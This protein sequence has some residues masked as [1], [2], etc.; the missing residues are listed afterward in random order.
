M[1]ERRPADDGDGGGGLPLS[2]RDLVKLAGASTLAPLAG[3]ASV[4]GGDVS[5]GDAGGVAYGYGGA[6]VELAH[7]TGDVS[8]AVSLP[9]PVARWT[10]DEEGGR[11]V[12]DVAGGHHGTTEGRPRLGRPGVR[13]AGSMDCRRRDGNY[14]R[15]PSDPELVPTA[16]L[17]FGGWFRTRSSAVEQTVVQK[18]TDHMWGSGYVLDVQTARS[19]RARVGV[20]SGRA[21]VNPWADFDPHDGEWH[22]LFAT[23]DGDAL[24][25]YYDGAEVGRDESQ[26]GAVRPDDSP[27]YLGRGHNE[28]NDVYDMGGAIDDV[29]VYDVALPAASVKALYDGTSTTSP[30]T[31]TTTTTSDP[32]TTTTSVPTTTTT[33]T[34]RAP[35]T[36]STTT[37]TT[38]TTTTSGSG[39]GGSGG[40]TTTTSE[41]TT[42]TTTPEPTTT[43]TSSPEDDYGEQ[44][45]GAYG[46]GG[47]IQ[48]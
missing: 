40:S 3:C 45:Y 25:C 15:V 36:T 33:A 21:F 13:G 26:S 1:D 14:V 7:V 48:S 22:H 39:G 19:F 10:L 27:L 24:V 4:L 29:R 5:G 31:P 42:T 43:T 12:R 16:E 6:R 28:W 41:P 9:E 32:T 20:D 23:W 47:T 18:A 37:T 35:T 2:R 8:A 30:E 11:T 17:S 38:V 46:Y 34:T 44:G